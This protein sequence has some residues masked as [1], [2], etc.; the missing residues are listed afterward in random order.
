MLRDCIV[1]VVCVGLLFSGT[2]TAAPADDIKALLKKG[3]AGAAYALGKAHPDQLGNPTFDLHFG[4]AAIDAGNAGEGV[5]ALERYVAHF[6]DNVHARFQL[7]RG[8]FILGE[9]RRAR[10]E[11]ADL[12]DT[13]PPAAVTASIERFL[14]AIRAREAAYRTTSGAFVGFGLGYDSNINGGV[15][16]ASISLPSL[17]PITLYPSGVQAEAI[18]A[19]LTGGANIVHPVA[20]GMSVFGS[21]AADYRFHDRRQRFDRNHWG[22]TGGLSYFREQNQL[23]GSLSFNSLN[24]DNRRYRDIAS[25]A[26]EWIRQLDRFQDVSF[27]LQYAGIDHA[28]SNQVRD[29]HLRGAGVGYRRSL[30]GPWR[31]QLTLNA[32][33]AE[34]NNRHGRDEFSRDLYG[35]RAAIGI[36]PAP[37]WSARAGV[38]YQVS[39]YRMPDVLLAPF[40]RH[41]KHLAFDLAGSYALNRNLSIRGELLFARND[42]NLALYRYG[43]EVASINIRYDFK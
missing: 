4:I 26:G 6:P 36:S 7:A 30:G 27:G 21:I 40:P 11:F 41:D 35:M 23:R 18:F 12:L 13:R 2:A 37:R 10:A 14:D 24:V 42:S 5:L 34:E 29:A 15:S 33:L 25:I 39:D 38:T 22:M 43:R 16:E 17:G 1:C 32:N 3:D 19:R 28:G 31:T 8:Y 20:P 9:N